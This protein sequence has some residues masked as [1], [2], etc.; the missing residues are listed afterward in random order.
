[1]KKINLKSSEISRKSGNKRKGNSSLAFG[2]LLLIVSLG[3]F[4]GVVYMKSETENKITNEEAQIVDIK[5]KMDSEDYKELYDFQ[6]RLSDVEKIVKRKVIQYE[7][8]ERISRNTIP[9]VFFESINV[10]VENGMTE[11]DSVI[12]APDHYVLSQQLEAYSLMKGVEGVLLTNSSQEE[13][14]V[15]GNIVFTFKPQSKETT[16]ESDQTPIN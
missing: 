14:G 5:G 10:K 1:M 13:E 6:S 16:D 12:I 15:T 3:L 7:F 4:G 11:Y 2:V 9:S 8:L